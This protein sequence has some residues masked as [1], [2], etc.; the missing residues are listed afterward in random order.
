MLRISKNCQKLLKQCWNSA[1][2]LQNSAEYYQKCWIFSSNY[3]KNCYI[4]ISLRN[5]TTIPKAVQKNQSLRSNQ[6]Q[7][8]G[9]F[10]RI[11]LVDKPNFSKREEWTKQ[12]TKLSPSST[13]SNQQAK[14]Q[15]T[16]PLPSSTTNNQQTKMQ[17]INSSSSSITR[18]QQIKPQTQTKSS[19]SSSPLTN[20]PN[21]K[22]T[23]LLL[24]ITKLKNSA[25]SNW[26]FY[27]QSSN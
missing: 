24:S 11:G 25:N 1:Q 9:L 13:T 6:L 7:F 3:Q 8:C 21:Y 20:K 5:Q 18:H 14:L 27:R 19:P 2:N 16:K 10:K 22:F 26:P 17:I 23:Y 4:T 12:N 15:N